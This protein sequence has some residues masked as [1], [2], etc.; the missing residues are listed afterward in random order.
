MS[1]KIRWCWWLSQ[2]FAGFATTASMSAS[3]ALRVSLI[4]CWI[5]DDRRW[6][7]DDCHWINLVCDFISIHSVYVQEVWIH[8]STWPARCVTTPVSLI[9]WDDS[10]HPVSQCRDEQSLPSSLMIIVSVEPSRRWQWCW[11]SHRTTAHLI[12]LV[13]SNCI[14]DLQADNDFVIHIDESPV[15]GVRNGD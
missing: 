1:D 11:V 2:L 5:F 10:V 12:Q 8:H 13:W 6:F 15:D 3:M 7:I 9:L 14:D 4:G